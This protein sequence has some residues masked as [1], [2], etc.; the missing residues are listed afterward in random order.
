MVPNITGKGPPPFTDF[1]LTSMCHNR[2][3]LFGGKSPNGPDNTV[4]I[5]QCV[6]TAVVSAIYHCLN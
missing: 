1:T 5:G 3:V 6:K 2:A 4:Y